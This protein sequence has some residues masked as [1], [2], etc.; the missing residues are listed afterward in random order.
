MAKF[1]KLHRVIKGKDF[2]KN[3]IKE[4]VSKNNFINQNNNSMI[5]S[6]SPNKSNNNSK[7]NLKISKE[8]ELN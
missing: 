5:K 8:K 2:M 4:A 7:S 6:L 1:E 3:K